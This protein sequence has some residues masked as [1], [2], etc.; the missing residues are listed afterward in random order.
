[1]QIVKSKHAEAER[2]QAEG[3]G[4]EGQVR[5]PRG[6]HAGCDSVSQWPTTLHAIRI[7]TVIAHDSAN[8][9]PPLHNLSAL[10]LLVSLICYQGSH[11]KHAFVLIT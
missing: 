3:S 1:M 5:S 8:S 6:S 10:G 9:V 7:F 2:S 11:S 4:S